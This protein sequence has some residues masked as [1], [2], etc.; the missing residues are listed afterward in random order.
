MAK[1]LVKDDL[2]CLTEKR[3]VKRPSSTKDIQEPGSSCDKN[4]ICLSDETE[5]RTPEQEVTAVNAVVKKQS[6]SV[7]QKCVKFVKENGDWQR[8]VYSEWFHNMVPGFTFGFAA[9]LLHF[10][11]MPIAATCVLSIGH[12]LAGWK[13]HDIAHDPWRR[14]TWLR[15]MYPTLFCGFTSSW[16]DPMHNAYHHCYPNMVDVDKDISTSPFLMHS[17]SNVWIHQFQH[18]YHWL[19]FSILKWSWRIRSILA[20]SFIELV[21]IMLHY[22]IGC[23]IFGAWIFIISIFMDGEV[24]AIILSLNHD[25]E[26]KTSTPGDFMLQTLRSTIDID[27]PWGLGWLF[28][29]VQYQ[30]L[31]HLF[32]YI[33]SYRYENLIPVIKRYCNEYGLNYRTVPLWKAWLN[34]KR[35]YYHV[36]RKPIVGSTM[37]QSCYQDNECNN[38][39]Y[40]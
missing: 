27:V 9:W 38:K 5:Q 19:P 17:I 28:G 16:W 40:L 25:A 29:N 39:K 21:Y 20:S 37:K 35:Y 30:T 3:Q 4:E 24:S 23:Y 1:L 15:L 33:P 6:P 7:Y 2:S 12:I 13:S 10:H 34:H 22:F 32:P 11:E 18:L 8:N 31:H 36:V 26:I 14:N